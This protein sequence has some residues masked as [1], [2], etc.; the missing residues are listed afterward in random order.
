MRFNKKVALVTG[1]SRGIGLAI[2][3]RLAAEGCAVVLTGRN[4]L[5]GRAAAAAIAEENGI[6]N[7]NVL[8]V[9]GDLKLDCHIR[10]VLGQIGDRF[11]KLDVLVNNAG[12]TTFITEHDKAIEDIEVSSWNTILNGAA[13]LTLMVSKHSVPLL[14]AAGGGA[15]VNIS[16]AVASRGIANKP[17]HSASKAAVEALTRS[18]AVELAGDGIRSNAVS[19]GFIVSGPRQAAVA[20]DPIQGAAIR[21][22][23]LLRIGTSDDVAAA[24]AFLASQEAAFITGVVLPVDG[25][26]ACRMPIPAVPASRLATH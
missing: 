1:S 23:Q 12:P 9:A 26:V 10:S 24:V 19:L 2:A 18:L 7:D 17:A 14:R 22:M 8:F 3:K 5:E 13:T 20:A 16:T 21:A 6:G 25:G 4:E 11:G 15:I